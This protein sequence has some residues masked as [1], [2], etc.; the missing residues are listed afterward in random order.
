VGKLLEVMVNDDEEMTG[1]DR[2]AIAASREFFQQG[3]EGLSFEEVVADCGLTM[4]QVRKHE[5]DQTT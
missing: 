4:E 5:G 3:N 2:R 1:E